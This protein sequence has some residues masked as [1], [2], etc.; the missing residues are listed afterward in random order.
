MSNKTLSEIQN[1]MT[2]LLHQN[3]RKTEEFQSLFVFFGTI[4]M[5][6]FFNIK[7]D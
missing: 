5:L 2:D 4:T 7:D 6:A 3:F 1:D